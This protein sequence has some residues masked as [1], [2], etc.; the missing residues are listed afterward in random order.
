MAEEPIVIACDLGE[1][2]RTVI[3]A[4]LSLAQWLDASPVLVH[5]DAHAH[6]FNESFHA[7]DDEDLRRMKAGYRGQA[8][9][10]MRRIA[11]DLGRAHGT[12]E[13]VVGE[14]RPY[15]AILAVAEERKAL[16]V[17]TGSHVHTGFERLIVGRNAIRVARLAGC[18]VFTVDV[19][20]PWKGISKIVYASDLREGNRNAEQW[21][22]RL[23]GTLGANLTLL[24]VSELGSG[25]TMPY[26]VVPRVQEELKAALEERLEGL[27]LAL[28]D[29]AAKFAAGPAGVRARLFFAHDPAAAILEVAREEQADLI[30]LGTHGRR[31][32]VRALLGSVAEGVLHGAHTAVL[33]VHEPR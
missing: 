14:G 3:E 10:A 29:E 8:M 25:M 15:E 26:A 5:V 33:T 18:G 6:I 2:A 27:K 13:T 22:A 32:I 7:V 19:H 12:F 4:G 24:H 17:V 21:T 11:E 28:A 16:A 9:T 23:A 30:V 31:G 20:R 1:T